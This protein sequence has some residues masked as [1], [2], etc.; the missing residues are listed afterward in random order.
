MSLRDHA[1]AVSLAEALVS[2]R[3]A[4]QGLVTQQF[5]IPRDTTAAFASGI[6]T[7][8]SVTCAWVWYPVPNIHRYGPGYGSRHAIVTHRP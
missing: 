8:L 5:A 7:R 2:A 1:A 4:G 6:R 3:K